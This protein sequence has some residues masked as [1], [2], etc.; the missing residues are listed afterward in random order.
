MKKKIEKVNGFTS[1]QNQND[2]MM[3]ESYVEEQ[4]ELA[5]KKKASNGF[6]TSMSKNC[7]AEIPEIKAPVVKTAEVQTIHA[8]V[9]SQVVKDMYECF[10]AKPTATTVRFRDEDGCLVMRI[11][12]FYGKRLSITF[13]YGKRLSRELS[14]FADTDLI[15]RTM[16]AMRGEQLENLKAY[17]EEEHIIAAT[18]VDPRIDIFRQCMKSTLKCRINPDFLPDEADENKRYISVS[19]IIAPKME[20]RFCL[21]RTSEI[22]EIVNETIKA[23]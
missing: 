15:G 23:A 17:C 19:F 5:E 1:T 20:F 21:E 14:L 9:S 12:F 2:F 6:T 10:M 16:R 3:I 22:E 13:F 7:K 4:K 11:T 18:N 8:R